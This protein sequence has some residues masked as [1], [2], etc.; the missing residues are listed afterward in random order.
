[1]EVK[2]DDTDRH[3]L[4]LLQRDA[5]ESAASL[6]RKLHIARTT[7]LSRIQRLERSGVVAGYGL[8]LGRAV[9]AEALQV[10]CGLKV[11]PRAAL[12]VIA[13]LER[14]HVVQEV[15]AVSG[16]FDYMVILRCP[17]TER[18][19]ALLDQVGQIEG[20]LETRS[21]VVLSKKI[22]ARCRTW[23]PLAEKAAGAARNWRPHALP[24]KINLMPSAAS[25]APATR[26]MVHFAFR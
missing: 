5:R 9:E 14:L 7:V 19:D 20:V 25:S 16:Q 18:L 1:M 22:E 15:S 23:T 12:A 24:D 2:L 21:S 26:S 17:S 10:Y 11:L 4:S 8:R 6:A 13:A 3:L